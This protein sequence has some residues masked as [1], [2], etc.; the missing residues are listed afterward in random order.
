MHAAAGGVGRL[1]VQLATAA[2]AQVLGTV[3][4]AVK[5]D[6]ARAAGAA[7]VIRYDEVDFAAAVRD[8]T[9]G[10]GVDAVYDAINR[11]TFHAS[12]RTVRRRG[13]LVLYGE[14]SGQVDPIAPKQLQAAGSVIFTYPSLLD[15]VAEPAELRERSARLFAAVASGDL[16]LEV[17][18]RPLRDA[19]AAHRDLERRRTTGKLVLVP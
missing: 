19:A 18:R 16:R 9:A 17:E 5:A 11:E 15:F 2:G 3:S 7:E 6:V 13:T 12:L 4:S 10:R 8:L 1:L 14:A